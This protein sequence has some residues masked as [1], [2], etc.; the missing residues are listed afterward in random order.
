VVNAEAN[1]RLYVLS[2]SFTNP[3]EFR[4]C[5]KC[6]AKLG[7]STTEKAERAVMA[8]IEIRDK[9]RELSLEISIGINM[10]MMYFGPYRANKRHLEIIALGTDINLAK[11]LQETAKPSQV[12]VRSR[13]YKFTKRAFDF[14]ELHGLT[15]RGIA[16]PITTYEA[17]RL[18]EHPEKLRGIEE[19]HPP[20]FILTWRNGVYPSVSL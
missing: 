17:I 3:S 12:L 16:K 20:S 9:V 15:L 8:A 13:T 10:G 19:F 2:V 11:R 14:T 1:L 6:G 7:E 18:K 5:G 4:F